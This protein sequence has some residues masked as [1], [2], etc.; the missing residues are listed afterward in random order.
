MQ[1]LGLSYY[2]EKGFFYKIMLKNLNYSTV[3]LYWSL[4]IVQRIQE[5]QVTLI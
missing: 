2:E 4:Y 1:T 5:L 3:C